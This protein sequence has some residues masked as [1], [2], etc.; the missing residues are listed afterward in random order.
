MLGNEPGLQLVGADDVA[1]QQV[2]RTIV[3]VVGGDA[4]YPA[5]LLDDELVRVK[6][7]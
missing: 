5:C 7:P 3:A 1:H 2:I 4:R 6:Q